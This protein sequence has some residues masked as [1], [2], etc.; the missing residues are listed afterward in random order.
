MFTYLFG[1]AIA[2]DVRTY[3]QFLLPG[4]LVQTS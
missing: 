3:L 2:G 1:G 4:I